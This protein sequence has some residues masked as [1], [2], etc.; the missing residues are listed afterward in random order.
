MKKIFGYTIA[1]FTLLSGMTSCSQE[2]E[3]ISE[4]G[5][6]EEVLAN[7]NLKVPSLNPTRDY[8]DGLTALQLQYGVYEKSAAGALNLVGTYTDTFTDL[9]SNVSI[10]LVT[11]RSYVLVFWGSA[12]GEDDTSVYSITWNQTSN[13]TLSVNYDGVLQNDETRDA[14]FA[15]KELEVTG[16]L[17]ENVYLYRP[18]AQVNYGTDDLDEAAVKTCF[19]EDWSKLNT[20]LTTKAYS[21]LDLISGEVSNEVDVTFGMAGIPSDEAFP[22]QPD[23]YSYLSMDYLLVPVAK[24]IVPC[25][26]DVYNTGD[27]ANAEDLTP[28][29]TITIAEVPVQRNYQTNIIGQL[30]TS[31]NNFKVI[32]VPDFTE[33]PYLVNVEPL[34][35]EEPAVSEDG[36]SNVISTPEQWNYI[37]QN[38]STLKNITLA[39]DID[40]EGKAVEPMRL[41]SS[42]VVDGNGYT[43][44]NVN[45]VPKYDSTSVYA[46]MFAHFGITVKNVTFENI[47]C[48]QNIGVT[49]NGYTLENVFMGVVIGGMQ[50]GCVADIS[51]V[52][53]KNCSLKGVQSVG[54]ICGYQASNST[55]NIDNCTISNVTLTNYQN[56]EESGF[57]AGLVGK[58]MGTVTGSGNVL[59]D[60]VITGYYGSRDVSTIQKF[61]GIRGASANVQVTAEWGAGCVLNA[62]KIPEGN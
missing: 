45:L 7:F 23:T 57:V 59:T 21:Q 55:L 3:V 5:T 35:T 25:T 56:Y 10:K 16:T 27:S 41:G 36:Q 61:V 17:N 52:T 19:G 48:D 14:F 37:V 18:F 54:A 20:K 32:I 58:T 42:Y 1:A 31:T 34:E 12:Y 60:V 49:E 38:G 8:G 22:Y 44:K 28:I 29:N 24:S 39:G 6:G 4:I 40:F 53:V 51:N 46:G 15:S 13:P 26:F 30:L 47:R 62:I 43:I 33:P 11:G 2:N 50:D 9:E